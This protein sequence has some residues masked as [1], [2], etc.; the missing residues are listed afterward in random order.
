MTT[1]CTVANEENVAGV[2]QDYA[3]LD[4]VRR[5][6][7]FD[8]QTS[9]GLLLAVPPETA[10]AFLAALLAAGHQAAEVGEVLE[11]DARIEVV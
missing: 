2:L 11:G 3:K 4:R 10:P 8:P 7:L 5:E 6:I 9:G 1:G